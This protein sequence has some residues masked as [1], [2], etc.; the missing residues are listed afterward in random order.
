MPDFTPAEEIRVLGVG[1]SPRKGGN[2]DILMQH[3]L[4]GAAEENVITLGVQLRDCT[5]G[6]CTGCE[7]CRPDHTCHCQEDD[8]GRL[9][10]AVTASQG[11]VLIS[12][13]H[14]Y[15]ITSWMKAFIDRL[16]CFY[17]VAGS[18]PRTY[19]SCLAG[20]GRKALIATVTDQVHKDEAGMSLQAMRRPLERLGYDVLHEILV[21]G[22]PEKGRVREKGNLLHQVENMG[23]HL[24]RTLKGT[25]E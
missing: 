25:A 5:V 12:P 18:A 17:D 7:E 24:A 15:N 4:K 22:I 16:Y 11:L 14:Q 9:Y 6:G 3:I 2:S 20:Q 21:F 8:M 23:G 1:A 19:S 10:G 13:T